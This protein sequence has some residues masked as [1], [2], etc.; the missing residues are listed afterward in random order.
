MKAYAIVMAGIIK[1]VVAGMVSSS[2]MDIANF[3]FK[4]AFLCETKHN[5]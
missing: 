2:K 1:T 4:T 3:G 5:Y